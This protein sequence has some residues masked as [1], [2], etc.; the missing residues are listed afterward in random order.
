MTR[1][2]E[3]ALWAVVLTAFG[4]Q[5]VEQMISAHLS[6]MQRNGQFDEQ[7]GLVSAEGMAELARILFANIESGERPLLGA[8]RAMNRE[9]FRVL[10]RVKRQLSLLFLANL[11]IDLVPAGLRRLRAQLDLSV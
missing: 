10:R 9:H 6:L 11:P 2:Q 3:R 5:K 4:A 7:L 8:L 1:V